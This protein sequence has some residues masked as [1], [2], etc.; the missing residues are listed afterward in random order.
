MIVKQIRDTHRFEASSRSEH[1]DDTYVSCAQCFDRRST[2]QQLNCATPLG[3]R[4]GAQAT[5][6]LKAGAARRPPKKRRSFSS[7]PVFA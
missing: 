3:R 2:G 4:C 5:G 7:A 6:L 1:W